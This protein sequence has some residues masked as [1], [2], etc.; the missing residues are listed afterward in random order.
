[1]EKGVGQSTAI[2]WLGQLFDGEQGL[3]QSGRK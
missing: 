3:S 2:L 1:M